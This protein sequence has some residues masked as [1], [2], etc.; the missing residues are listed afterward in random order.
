MLACL[1]VVCGVVARRFIRQRNAAGAGKSI[2]VM[3]GVW[4]VL[5]YISLG[6]APLAITLW[7]EAR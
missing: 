7:R 5:M 6:A 1:V 3:A 4:T 2:E